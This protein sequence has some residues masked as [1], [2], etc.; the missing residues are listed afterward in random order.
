M[1]NFFSSP[2]R[3]LN[4]KDV[5]K[6]GI[7]ERYGADTA[8]VLLRRDVVRLINPAFLC[9]LE[10][11]EDA[12]IAW[13]I[14]EAGYIYVKVSELQAIHYSSLEVVLYQKRYI[15]VLAI[16]EFFMEYHFTYT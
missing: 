8:H 12:Y 5:I 10:C 1:F 2:R 6:H 14:I 3:C 9:Q 15:E 7:V 4:I 13:K 11:G 16:M